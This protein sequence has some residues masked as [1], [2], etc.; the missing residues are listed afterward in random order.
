MAAPSLDVRSPAAC[1]SDVT[2]S[3]CGLEDV[4]C[5]CCAC[6]ERWASAGSGETPCSCC[7]CSC[8]SICGATVAGWDWSSPAQ[9]SASRASAVT[10]PSRLLRS[11]P[12]LVASSRHAD[13]PLPSASPPAARGENVAKVCSPLSP[14]AGGDVVLYS[15]QAG[16]EGFPL[17]MCA[18][19][20]V[21]LA[22]APGRCFPLPPCSG[23]RCRRQRGVWNDHR[24]PNLCCSGAD[25]N[26]SF[27]RGIIPRA[28]E[29][30][31]GLSFIPQPP[32]AGIDD[33]NG[34]TEL[35]TSR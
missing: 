19:G 12:E 2:A 30:E 1:R 32:L 22:A 20:D 9:A 15:E 17:P 34:R 13:P 16:F 4:V 27:L 10:S 31:Q 29:G 11:F 35:P 33:G 23:G 6:W 5:C 24:P 28:A 26:S 3:A 8:N 14:C 7:S 21:A 25:Q 18:G